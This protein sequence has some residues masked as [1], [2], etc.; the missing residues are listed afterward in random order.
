M[1]SKMPKHTNSAYTKNACFKSL[2]YVY[3]ISMPWNTSFLNK[4]LL[5]FLEHMMMIMMIRMM[6]MMM[7]TKK[8][9]YERTKHR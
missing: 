7:S 9:D 8:V 5:D 6:M 3:K 2:D 1:I 4:H